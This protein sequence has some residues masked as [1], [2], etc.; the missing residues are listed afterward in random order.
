MVFLIEKK[1]FLMT[2][3]WVVWWILNFLDL[4]EQVL[5]S[6]PSKKQLPNKSALNYIRIADIN[7]PIA[8]VHVVNSRPIYK[9]PSIIHSRLN[10]SITKW[11]NK[12]AAKLSFCENE[13]IKNYN[14]FNNI[15]VQFSLFSFIYCAKLL[16]QRETP[17]DKDW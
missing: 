1:C 6:F 7:F 4:W 5:F 13:K 10:Y 15:N 12:T 14:S 2:W 9:T 3:L 17:R 11:T 16:R 8:P